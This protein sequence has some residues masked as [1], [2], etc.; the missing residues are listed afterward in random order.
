VI[1]GHLFAGNF[2]GR[3]AGRLAHV[4]A[5][6]ATEHNLAD[7][8]VEPRRYFAIDRLLSRHTDR[9]V[10]VC[11]RV[12]DS[13]VEQKGI[14]ARK[15]A[16]IP[17]AVCPEH[18]PDDG[19]LETRLELKISS[20]A[21]VVGFVG[22]FFPEKNLFHFL[23]ALVRVR[24]SSPAM[25]G[26]LVGDGP[27]FEETQAQAETLGLARSLRFTGFREDISR[28]L[29]A[30]DVF[31]L[32]SAT[33]G[34]SMTLLEAMAAGKPAVVSTVGGSQEAVVDG[35]TGFTVSP[36]DPDRLGEAIAR[37]L[38]EPESRRR[39]GEAA[40]QRVAREFSSERQVEQL[41]ALYE[42]IL[43]EK[44]ILGRSSV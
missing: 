34:L 24:A 12:A 43:R 19:G 14:P 26:L 2:W 10:A 36:G 44:G 25:V 20:D 37:L 33:E 16:T 41:A 21:P 1:Q 3:T 42:S 39:M 18:F 22:R 9:I 8:K 32:P 35:V 6:I 40:R 15:I 17:N 23:Q 31:V 38:A 4:P 28:L 30:M 7:G 27:L 11:A 13:L 29:A 5:I